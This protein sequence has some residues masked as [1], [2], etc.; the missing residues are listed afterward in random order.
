[1]QRSDPPESSRLLSWPLR[2]SAI[3]V[4]FP[5]AGVIFGASIQPI[6][7]HDYWWHLVM[8]RYISATGS[9]PDANLF[10]YTME[11]GARFVDQPW[12]SQ[13][14]MFELREWAGDVGLIWARNLVVA[15]SW[16]LLMYLALRRVPRPRIVGAVALVAVLLS[17]LTYGVRTQMFALIPYAL[18]LGLLVELAERRAGAAW[19]LAFL[20]LTALWAN[21][22]GSF[23]LA[24][25]LIF[26]VGCACVFE[27]VVEK[28]DA[29]AVARAWTTALAAA[30][31]GGSLTPHGV[32]VYAYVAELS[33]F[34]TVAQTVTE[35]QSP[36]WNSFY[37]AAL[38]VSVG[39]GGAC[40]GWRRREVSLWEVVVFSATAYLAADAIRNFYWFAAAFVVILSPHIVAMIGEPDADAPTESPAESPAL[41]AALALLLVALP[42]VAQP[43][44]PVFER[45]VS[46]LN[47]D[48]RRT[49]PGVAVHS[50]E[51]PMRLAVMLD[52][53]GIEGRLFHAQAVGGLVEFVLAPPSGE[54]V[55]FVDQRMELI[56]ESVWKEYFLVSSAASGWQNVLADYEIE[57]ALL[58]TLN[59]SRLVEAM[60]ASDDWV[61][62]AED[63]P[64]VMFIAASSGQLTRW[65]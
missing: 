8:G 57:A 9:I 39:A 6:S 45:V 4:L 16:A 54:Q 22:H 41:N 23:A 2:L 11:S 37:G 36:A 19:G 30:L 14:T 48:A 50:T 27:A 51:S 32:G 64:Y 40:L 65:R 17:G 31:I 21:L 55:A 10:L 62:V 1:M 35:W 24:P 61:R 18:L 52:E 33:L 56:P 12:L 63:G 34:S 29:T 13:W 26:L 3:W 20:P 44:S 58:S 42:L 47:P 5:L 15:V 46:T 25:A 59:Q 49:A 7:P 60:S 43:A 53:R 38:L 28:G